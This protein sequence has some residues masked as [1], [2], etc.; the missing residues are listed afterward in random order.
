MTILL[1]QYLLDPFDLFLH[2]I[3]ILSISPPSMSLIEKNNMHLAEEGK[4]S[5]EQFLNVLREVRGTGD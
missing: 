5:L 2:I 4:I 3:W 1:H